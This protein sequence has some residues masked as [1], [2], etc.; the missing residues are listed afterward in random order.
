MI[1]LKV[2]LVEEAI[3]DAVALQA[4]L[5]HAGYSVAI[6]RV[7]SAEALAM[8]LIRGPWDVVLSDYQLPAM[9]ALEALK[10]CQQSG[11]DAP[12]IVVSG[13]IGEDAVVDLLKAGAS[14]YV[15][16]SRLSRLGSAIA[17]GLGDA[18]VR[19][20]RRGAEERIRR[21][22]ISLA[23]TVGRA[24]EPRDPYTAGHQRRVAELSRLVGRKLGCS[25]AQQEGLYVGGLLHDI[26]KM[27]IPESILTKPGRLTPEE[28]E[29]VKEHVIVGCDVLRKADLPWPVAEMALRHHER[30][31]GSGYP[32]GLTG[33]SLG[34]ESRLLA[35]CNVVEAMSSHRP[36]RPASSPVLVW[37]EMNSGKG[38]LYD[39]RVV[40]AI[41]DVIRNDEF[42]LVH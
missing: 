41:E 6:E 11:C 19:R 17:R 4:E 27:A 16:K 22:S 9:S 8:A 25:V 35:A 1:P 5:E 18:A 42:R 37:E 28:W 10:L 23:E 33:D 31:D 39:A 14:D 13:A 24:M 34:F 36:Y 21:S 40:E 15:V 38:R 30:L 29:I 26:G 2:L 3:E 12:F 32:D 20:E 7:E